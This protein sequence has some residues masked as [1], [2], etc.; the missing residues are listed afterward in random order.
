[1]HDALPTG[2]DEQRKAPLASG[3]VRHLSRMEIGGGGQIVIQGK[4]AFIGYQKGPDGFR[5]SQSQD[6]LND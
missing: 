3:N 2:T 6:R 1:M 5:S 4:Y